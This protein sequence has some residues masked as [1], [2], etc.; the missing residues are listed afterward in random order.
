MSAKKADGKSEAKEAKAPDQETTAPP[1]AKE[2]EKPPEETPIAD[3][4]I[5][6]LDRVHV[7]T[8]RY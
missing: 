6:E 1:V 8:P 3:E 2:A 5:A 4:I 7:R